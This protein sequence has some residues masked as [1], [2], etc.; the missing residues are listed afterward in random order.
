MWKVDPDKTFK[1]QCLYMC[2]V[3][4]LSFDI[5]IWRLCHNTANLIGTGCVTEA[6]ATDVDELV[7][8]AL[9]GGDGVNHGGGAGR[10][11]EGKAVWSGIAPRG[12]DALLGWPRDAART[13]R[14]GRL[15]NCDKTLYPACPCV[16]F[17]QFSKTCFNSSDLNT[18]TLYKLYIYI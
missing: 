18:Y 1:S 2:F 12:G 4:T 9:V 3:F 5:W 6:H 7:K 13:C 11:G 10:D 8:W 17:I 16:L 15:N 14:V